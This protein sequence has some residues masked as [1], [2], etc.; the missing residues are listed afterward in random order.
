M[1][2][3]SIIREHICRVIK[4]KHIALECL[5]AYWLPLQSARASMESNP[6]MFDERSLHFFFLEHGGSGIGS[7]YKHFLVYSTT[8][9]LIT[10]R[11]WGKP[12]GHD[13]LLP[14]NEGDTS[15]QFIKG[16]SGV[17]HYPRAVCMDSVPFAV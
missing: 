7:C 5:V 17:G 12:I 14:Q 15:F 8:S 6:E 11:S 13:F 9:V 4:L 1:G 16:F 3:A 10:L 2:I